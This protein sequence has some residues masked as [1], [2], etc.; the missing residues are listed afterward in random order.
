MLMNERR[1]GVALFLAPIQVAIFVAMTSRPTVGKGRVP[2]V[3][4]Q[5][6]VHELKVRA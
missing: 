1:G 4:K 3:P 2:Y 6:D 5:E